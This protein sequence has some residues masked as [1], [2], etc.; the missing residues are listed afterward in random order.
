MSNYQHLSRNAGFSPKSLRSAAL[1]VQHV[2]ADED[3]NRCK[4]RSWSVHTEGANGCQACGLE[5]Q[6]RMLLSLLKRAPH[7]TP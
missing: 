5:S 4:W 3:R 6:Q 1:S 2:S 7:G